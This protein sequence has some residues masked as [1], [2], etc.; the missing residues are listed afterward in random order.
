M[1][2]TRL[3]LLGILIKV[4]TNAITLVKQITSP[5]QR[6]KDTGN[7]TLHCGKTLLRI[8]S[9]LPTM[10]RKVVKISLKRKIYYTH[11]A[12]LGLLIKIET[13]G[14]HSRVADQKRC[15][16]RPRHCRCDCTLWHN[17]GWNQVSPANNALKTLLVVVKYITH[18]WLYWA[19]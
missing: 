12:L 6:D 2:H 7:A 1:I 13:N 8:K 17:P 16:T 14:K 15:P 9:R 11:L 5:V 19:F 18:V 10:H 4:E 3:A